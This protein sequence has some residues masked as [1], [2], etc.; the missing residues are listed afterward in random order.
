MLLLYF[1]NYMQPWAFFGIACLLY[2]TVSKSSVTRA[3]IL[4]TIF[5]LNA[6]YIGNVNTFVFVKQSEW[7]IKYTMGMLN[8]KMTFKV[9]AVDVMKTLYVVYM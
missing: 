7:Y 2:M 3:V 8:L 9:F 5:T 6:T 4:K 1:A